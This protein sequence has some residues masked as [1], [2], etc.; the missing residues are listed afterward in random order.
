MTK[1][2]ENR[3]CVKT[4]LTIL[5]RMVCG[6]V[7]YSREAAFHNVDNIVHNECD[8]DIS[9]NSHLCTTDPVSDHRIA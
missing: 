9:C 8:I 5:I 3:R 7:N 1:C 2:D 6:T 4:Q